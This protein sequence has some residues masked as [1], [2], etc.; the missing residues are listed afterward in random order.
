M[1]FLPTHV[2]PEQPTLPTFAQFHKPW[3]GAYASWPLK[4]FNRRQCLKT[5]MLTRPCQLER[6]VGIRQGEMGQKW[7]KSGSAVFT[8]NFQVR[9]TLRAR[10]KARARAWMSEGS[11]RAFQKAKAKVKEE[12]WLCYAGSLG[13]KLY[14]T[15]RFAFVL[16]FPGFLVKSFSAFASAHS[17][18]LRDFQRGLCNYG[19]NCRFSHVVLRRWKNERKLRMLLADYHYTTKHSA[20]MK[21]HEAMFFPDVDEE[22]VGASASMPSVWSR[23]G[24]CLL[25][26]ESVEAAGAVARAFH[27]VSSR[28]CAL[29]GALR[30]AALQLCGGQL[31][32]QSLGQCT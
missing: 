17:R 15:F 20:N 2:D 24:R 25:L 9:A 6:L 16:L 14:A 18:E 1:W 5:G 19:D 10:A 32:W 11:W 12:R 27:S 4:S 28:R 26:A 21:P 3:G 23:L 13:M 8:I 30:P 22:S 31:R 7:L 29:A